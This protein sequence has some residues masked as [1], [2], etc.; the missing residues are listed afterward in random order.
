MID[1]RLCV[2]HQPPQGIN[3]A[4]ARTHAVAAGIEPHHVEAPAAELVQELRVQQGVDAG[5]GH[6]YHDRVLGLAPEMVKP[7]FPV[8]QV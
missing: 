4:P 5:P 3:A 6:E 8:L 1:D 2:L 7:Q